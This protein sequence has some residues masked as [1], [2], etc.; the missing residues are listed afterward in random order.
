MTS[1]VYG[2]LDV[3]KES[4]VAF[5]FSPETG[6]FREAQLG[7]DRQQLRQ[8]IT[9]WSELGTL[10]LCYEASNAG[11]VIKRWCDEW[12]VGC[13]VI[14]PSLI[15]R[16]PGDRVKTDRRDARKL[17]TLY[18]A[19]AL[20][21]IHVPSEAEEQVRALLRMRAEL[22]RD[23]TRTKNRVA[24][25][26]S[27][28]GLHYK[29]GR[30]SW[31]QTYRRWLNGLSL[32]AMDDVIL[33]AH[34][35]TLDHLECQRAGLDARIEEAS[36]WPVYAE[37]V[38]R[39]LCLRGI[40]VYSAMVLLTEIGDIRRFP[41]APQ[42]MSYFGLVPSEDSTGP[43]RHTGAITKAGNAY[44]RWILGQAAQNQRRRPGRSQRLH[45]QWQ[46][47]PAEVVAIARKAERRLHHKFWKIASRKES[48][49]AATAVAREMAGFVWAL[50]SLPTH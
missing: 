17:A 33:Q 38:Q 35:Q 2:G 40:Q 28:L 32:S 50:L 29:L 10:R 22:T 12:E 18:A 4:I 27:R 45:K 31:T 36:R 15:P 23:M 44:A 41:T 19:G 13:E 46:S 47:Q 43:H 21:A 34:L 49:I 8:A 48:S 14:A 7:N 26:L 5:L 3:H 11:Y 42:L 1:V 20:T 37:N 30:K 39:L 24:N 9:Q 16:A 25:H 6:E